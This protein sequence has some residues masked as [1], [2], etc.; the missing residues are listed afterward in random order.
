MTTAE[1]NA[2]NPFALPVGTADTKGKGKINY[3]LCT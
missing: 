3:V 2:D 1:Y